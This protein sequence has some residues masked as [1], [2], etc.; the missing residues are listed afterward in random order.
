MTAPTAERDPLRA[1]DTAPALRARLARPWGWLVALATAT[2]LA[3]RLWGE[4]NVGRGVNLDLML[5]A[6]VIGVVSI[7]VMW[8]PM[9]SMR[10]ARRAWSRLDHA[11]RRAT[12]VQLA[13]QGLVFGPLMTALVAAATEW[14]PATRLLG[15][16][17]AGSL[18]ITLGGSASLLLR[19]R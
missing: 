2:A 15:P 13:L 10:V 6:A 16:S 14:L 18:L 19:L 4:A 3:V 1:R 8:A 7:G 11:L 17:L 5:E 9:F 12:I